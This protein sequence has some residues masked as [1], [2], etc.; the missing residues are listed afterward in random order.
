MNTEI[1][2]ISNKEKLVDIRKACSTVI[3]NIAWYIEKNGGKEAYEQ[4]HFVR[5]GVAERLNI[6]QSLLSNKCKLMLDN[7]YRSP[8]MQQISYDNVLERLK[9]E[10]PN[11]NDEQY[12]VEMSNRVS[13]VEFAS[14]CTGGAVD[15]TIV[16]NNGA[17]LAM[18]TSLDEFTDTTYTF[19]NLV[20]A[21]AKANRAILVDVM[22]EA[23]FVNF[24]AEWWHWSYGD[25]EWACYQAN[26]TAIYGPI[27]L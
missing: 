7:A 26:K 16:D 19:S 12:E 25:R 9:K 20:S 15:L 5:K 18:G 22:V 8:T 27:N 1:K 23:G 17:Q 24:P 4:A 10:C 11:W 6:A 13:K 14:H 2:I 3:C 21:N